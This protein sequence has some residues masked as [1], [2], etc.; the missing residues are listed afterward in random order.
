MAGV[1]TSSAADLQNK[2]IKCVESTTYIKIF[3]LWTILQ[4]HVHVFHELY[5]VMYVMTDEQSRD[6][7]VH[8]L[9]SP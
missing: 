8:L 4:T 9:S 7:S 3:L 1:L 5:T 6:V 2:S